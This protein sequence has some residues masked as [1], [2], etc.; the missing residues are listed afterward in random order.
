MNHFTLFSRLNSIC[1]F[2]A[3]LCILSVFR[4]NLQQPSTLSTAPPT[5]CVIG[6]L[7]DPPFHV[8]YKVIYKDHKEQSSQNRS[9]RNT[10]GH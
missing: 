1:H 10:T 5:F 6:K 8:L 3:Q 4:C 7:T 9:L 2:F